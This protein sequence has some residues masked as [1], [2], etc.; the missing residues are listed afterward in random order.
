MP[1]SPTTPADAAQ[2]APSTAA[3]PG[4]APVLIRADLGGQVLGSVVVDG[5]LRA[6]AHGGLRI[7]AEVNEGHLRLLAHTMSLKYGYLRLPFGGAKA[8]VAGD[9]EAERTL[10]QA[11]VNRFALAVAPLLRSRAYVPAADMGTDEELIR[12][13]MRAAGAPLSPRQLRVARSGDHTAWTVFHTLRLTAAAMHLPLAGLT[14]S[15]QGLGKVGAPLALLLAAADVRVVAVS[16][17]RGALYNPDGL[18]L[19]RLIAHAAHAGPRVVEDPAYGTR[20]QVDSLP[21]LP[22]GVLLPCAGVH[23]LHAGNAEAVQARIICP[24]ANQPATVEAEESL[25]RRGKMVIPDFLA[26]YGGVLGSVLEFACLPVPR[27][28][29]ILQ[30]HVESHLPRLLAL[31][32]ERQAPLREVAE[33][34]AMTRYRSMA[35]QGAGRRTGY[36]LVDLGVWM[37]HRGLIP[38]A[39]FSSFA[40]RAILRRLAWEA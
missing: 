9:P 34:L 13:A 26:N 6:R 25:V 24:G 5:W 28:R 4:H 8:A 11:L 27:V 22:V 19:P 21:G 12:G 18:D 31:A 23:T 30:A 15:L 3:P 29:E 36:G 40:A 7:E 39:I 38:S 32:D 37:Y 1:N 35:E 20:L 16:T 2:I 33:S 14:A 10:R 17:T